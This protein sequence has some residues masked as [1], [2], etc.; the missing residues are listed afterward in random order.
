VLQLDPYHPDVLVEVAT[1][2]REVGDE[3]WADELIGRALGVDPE[4]D[5]AR[6]LTDA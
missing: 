1:F 3:A 5:D 6:A 2:A 4:H